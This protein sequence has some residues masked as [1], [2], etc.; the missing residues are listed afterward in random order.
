MWKGT[1]HGCEYQEAWRIGVRLCRLAAT[2]LTHRQ[3]M[4]FTNIREA[5]SSVTMMVT[6]DDDDE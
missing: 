3:S 1:T 4:D 5:G 2:A 6:D